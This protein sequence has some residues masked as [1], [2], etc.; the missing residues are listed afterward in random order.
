MKSSKI[1]LILIISCIG[2]WLFDPGF[3]LA[4]DKESLDVNVIGILGETYDDNVTYAQRNLID[5][6]ITDIG[7]GLNLEYLEKRRAFGISGD[8]VRHSFAERSDFD[9][10]SADIRATFVNELSKF[11]RLKVKNDFYYGEEPRSFEEGFG[12]DGGRYSFYK[13]KFALSYE[14]DVSK[15]L[16]LTG[17]YSNELYDVTRQDLRDSALNGLGI[18]SKY[19]VNSHIFVNSFY[20]FALREYYPGNSVQQHTFGCGGR[21]FFTTQL[22][23]EAK[24]GFDIIDNNETMY[25]TIE[26]FIDLALINEFDEITNMRLGFNQ[27]SYTSEST[28]DIFDKW[29]IT[30]AL[31]RQ[32]LARLKGDIAAFYG[33]GTYVESKID[34]ELTGVKLGF[35]YDIN[36][37]I[38][39]NVYYSYSDVRS[40]DITREYNRNAI[41]IGIIAIF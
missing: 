32:L 40:G 22:S 4:L 12:R 6:F 10:T 5:D 37:K 30:C 27:R 2:Y 15:Q 3:V 11:T 36:P 16:S 20:S 29:Q 18:E 34:E 38:K 26:P 23:V 33:D 28:Q 9:N 31:T 35:I 14:K 17:R 13:N 39:G 8:I 25:N 19:V 24:A 41:S 21:Y 1:L 7:F